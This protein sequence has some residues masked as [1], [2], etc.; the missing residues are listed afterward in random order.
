MHA[1]VSRFRFFPDLYIPMPF[2]AQ[3][4]TGYNSKDRKI[5][6]YIVWN[7]FHELKWFKVENNLWKNKN[8][9][10][11]FKHKSEWFIPSAFIKRISNYGCYGYNR[12]KGKSLALN[13]IVLTI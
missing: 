7:P 8:E 13:S 5:F 1:K 10:R 12:L 9:T 4:L 11:I 3:L 6:K 2:N